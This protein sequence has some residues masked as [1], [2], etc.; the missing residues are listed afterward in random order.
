MKLNQLLERLE[1][2][3]V[4]GA[5]AIE[6]STLANDSRKVENGSAFVCISGAVVDGHEFIEDVAA[7]EL[8]QLSWRKRWRRRKE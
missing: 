7:K 3:V 2:E 1:Y 4:Q 6:I 8:L 5:D